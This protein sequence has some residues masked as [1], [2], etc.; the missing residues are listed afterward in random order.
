MTTVYQDIC[1]ELL[2]K[3]LCRREKK[4]DDKV[5]TGQKANEMSS[6]DLEDTMREELNILEGLAFHGMHNNIIEFD[7]RTRGGI[8]QHLKNDDIPV[9]KLLDSVIKELSFLRT[10]DGD[11]DVGKQSFHFLHLSIQ[12]FFAARY[13]AKQWTKQ[14]PI[15]MFEAKEQKKSKVSLRSFMNREKYSVRYEIFWRFVAG[16][17]HIQGTDPRENQQVLS[18]FF[19]EMEQ[20]AQDLLGPTHLR[21][22]MRCWNEVPVGLTLQRH[23]LHKQLA[24]RVIFEYDIHRESELAEEKEFP[25]E[26]LHSLLQ[27]QPYNMRNRVLNSVL[28]RSRTTEQ[29]TDW[30]ASWMHQ[31]LDQASL[32]N[33]IVNLLNNCH[34]LSQRS[35]NFLLTCLLDNSTMA[36][37]KEPRHWRMKPLTQ[38]LLQTVIKHLDD[39]SAQVRMAALDLLS[40]QPPFTL[41]TIIDPISCRLL[42]SDPKIREKASKF[43]QDLELPLQ[44]SQLL[45]GMTEKEDGR[46]TNADTQLGKQTPELE[47]ILLYTVSLLNHENYNVRQKAASTLRQQTSLSSS[48][49]KRLIRKLGDFDDDVLD[50]IAAMISCSSPELV[51]LAG[52]RLNEPK[53]VV[54]RQVAFVLGFVPNLSQEIVDMM[55]AQLDTEPALRKE[56]II[57][58]G[59]QS[60]LSQSILDR[61]EEIMRQDSDGEI[62]GEVIS[63][64][65]KHGAIS[66]NSL[67]ILL[68]DPACNVKIEAAKALDRH[69]DLPHDALNALLDQL[70]DE[71]EEV[72]KQA[73]YALQRPLPPE[74]VDRLVGCLSLEEEAVTVE[75]ILGILQYQHLSLEALSS[76]WSMTRHEYKNDLMELLRQQ[77]GLPIDI[78]DSLVQSLRHHTGRIRSTFI[79]I[80]LSRQSSLSSTTHY[81]LTKVFRR[82]P[83]EA[84][85][86][87]RSQEALPDE[88]INVLMPML[89][90]DEE[91]RFYTMNVLERHEN[92]Y[93]R[94]PHMPWRVIYYFYE[95]MLKERSSSRYIF[96]FR[97]Q[98]FVVDFPELQMEMPISFYHRIKLEL[99][100]R[101]S[102]VVLMKKQEIKEIRSWL[103]RVAAWVGNPKFWFFLV[104]PIFLSFFW[105]R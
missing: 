92:F 6:S 50:D 73:A 95:H 52:N 44:V 33:Y 2:R 49:T 104:F 4:M 80:I 63:A 100:F 42:D 87:L 48:I 105:P 61:F 14:D 37:L 65:A 34:F 97:A 75:H 55:A 60:K 70:Q 90:L 23:E 17:L 99:I 27:D 47:E 86:V 91:R 12:E 11:G 102:W 77:A 59:K 64:L 9:P 31:D 35:S 13:F 98:H 56:V 66:I 18:H 16:L 84:S 57:G 78:L 22:L 26:I 3:D 83:C 29:L 43:L 38:N 10:S 19:K 32:S 68:K 81:N 67:A 51:N 40:S 94:L 28:V 103:D 8:H 58:L 5:V 88:I 30:I 7:S 53:P 89:S 96:Y 93:H 101:L 20:G 62:K 69:S 21:L 54:Q 36:Y 41:Q 39:E 46:R 71:N 79:N 72:R 85:W 24:S 76:V 45:A 82:A 74:L 15:S 25:D 1:V